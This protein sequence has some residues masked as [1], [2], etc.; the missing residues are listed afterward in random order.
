MEL[1]STPSLAGNSFAESSRR[2]GVEAP[3]PPAEDEG[4]GSKLQSLLESALNGQISRSPTRNL[5]AQVTGNAELLL[6][7]SANS[8][9]P[10][11]GLD[12]QS[13]AE[14]IGHSASNVLLSEQLREFESVFERV[15]NTSHLQINQ[16]DPWTELTNQDDGSYMVGPVEYLAP[17]SSFSESIDV[18]DGSPHS[19]QTTSPIS[20]GHLTSSRAEESTAESEAPLMQLLTVASAA[21]QALED[22]EKVNGPM[23]S[24]AVCEVP[25]I[26]SIQPEAVAEGVVEVAEVA[27]EVMEQLSSSP[28]DI[29]SLNVSAND[30]PSTPT[31][32]AVPCSVAS[33]S[34]AG[35][36]DNSQPA[37]STSS[38]S[39]NNNNNNN[40]AAVT[41]TT[42]TTSKF[43]GSKAGR[44]RPSNKNSPVVSPAASGSCSPS[45]ASAVAPPKAPQKAHDDEH[46]VSRVNAI[47]EEYKEQL[48][49]S[50]DLQN[51]PAP[52]RYCM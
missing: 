13:A 11:V 26:Q 46:T 4:L 9:S 18:S 5:S 35:N 51:K 10:L 17:P 40:S 50:P 43:E 3:N 30:K 6:S 33:A 36:G 32:I 38:S 44:S 15:A 27:D 45:K 20:E 47:L 49:N 24:P 34:V 25:D 16:Q 2:F 23:T 12:P 42:A 1:G 52:R 22:E 39:S 41:T 19:R 8:I 37:F 7:D 21:R 31:R 28:A 14:N 29:S 48:R